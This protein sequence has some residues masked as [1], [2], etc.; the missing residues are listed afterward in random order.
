MLETKGSTAGEFARF[1]ADQKKRHD[2]AADTLGF[3]EEQLTVIKDTIKSGGGVTL[4][5]APR[6]QGLT[7]LSYGM[8]RA[9]D[10]FLQNI[11]TVERD[12]EQDL[13]G[14]RQNKLDRNSTPA[15]EQKLAS[16]IVSQQPDVL[17][18]SKPESPAAVIDLIQLAKEG[19]RVYF[20][21]NANSTFEALAAF[22]KLVGDPKLAVSQLQMV[23]CG[24]TLRK[25]CSACKQAYHP[26]PDTLRKLNMDASVVT[27]L[28]QARKDAIRDPKGNPIRC[29]FCNDLRYKG[30]TGMY[31]I[32]MVDEHIKQVAT[33]GMPADQNATPMKTAFRKQKGRYLQEVGLA[34]V[35]AGTTSVQE[36]LRVLKP[37]SDG[38]RS[39]GGSAPEKAPRKPK[40]PVITA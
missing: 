6:G 20:S 33:N 5:T 12:P 7:S 11:M 40:G 39:D 2:F 13:E 35:E 22:C 31:E 18:L 1:V 30:R 19:K 32:L 38:G 10:A 14:I 36:V 28:Y 26:D 29:D 34:L 27:E 17:L 37:S 24:R 8:L 9:H 21:F 23:I 4:L 25:L 15:E 16:W 3:S